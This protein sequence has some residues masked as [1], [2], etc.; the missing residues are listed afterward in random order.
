MMHAS[1]A[2]FVLQHR[3]VAWETSAAAAPPACPEPPGFRK[4]SAQAQLPQL[5]DLLPG[6]N[7]VFERRWIKRIPRCG[8]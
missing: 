2:E 6:G 3:L 4:P 1:A 5:S 7:V 8:V